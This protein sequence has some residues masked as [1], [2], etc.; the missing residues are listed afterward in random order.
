MSDIKFHIEQSS[1]WD[2]CS[3]FGGETCDAIISHIKAI[4]DMPEKVELKV[5]KTVSSIYFFSTL[6]FRI[7]IN[8]KAQQ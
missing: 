8:S 6:V 1:L 4:V 3:A 7:R 2:N 5:S